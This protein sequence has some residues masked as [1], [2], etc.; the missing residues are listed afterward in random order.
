MKS[1]EQLD[2]WIGNKVKTWSSRVSRA[3][4]SSELLEIRRDILADFRDNIQPKGQGKKVFPY[5]T[6]CGAHR[7]AECRPAN[8]SRRRVRSR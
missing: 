5:D 3:P 6:R 7:G 8:F 4:Q 1:L 2:S